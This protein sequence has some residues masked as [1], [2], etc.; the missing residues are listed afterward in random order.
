MRRRSGPNAW[1]ILA[2][3]LVVMA[4]CSTEEL[5]SPDAETSAADS[6]LRPGTPE[7][8]ASGDAMI[9]EVDANALDGLIVEAVSE[10]DYYVRNDT[11]LPVSLSATALFG[12]PVILLQDTVP[13]GGEALIYHALEGTGGHVMPSN[14]FHAFT[15]SQS[16]KTLYSGVR[17][18]DWQEG[19]GRY[20]LTLREQVNYACEQAADCEI[21]D[22]HNCCGYF[23]RCVNVDSPTPAPECSGVGSV[24]GWPEITHCTCE[25]NTC[26][27]MQGDQEV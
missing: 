27:S 20:T 10:A 4:G 6:G 15:A 13:A 21:K 12:E 16:G 17:D 19:S 23:P 25:K 11:S 7:S 9:E 24:C 18:A 5:T 3:S 26:R 14:F 8:D 22:V 1:H 2:L